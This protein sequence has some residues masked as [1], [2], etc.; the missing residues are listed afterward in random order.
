MLEGAVTTPTSPVQFAGR[1]KELKFM[2]NLGWQVEV[3]CATPAEWSQMLDLF[4]DANIY[5]TYAYGGVRWG[6]KNLSRIVLKRDGEV[7]GM[8][9]LRIVRPTPLKFGMAYLRWG[10]LCERRG[11]PLHPEVPTTMA[12]ALEEEYAGK[13][14]LFVRVLSNAFAGSPRAEAIRTA[15]SSFTR[16]PLTA[17]N[18]YRTFVLDLAP[19]L[20]ELRKSLDPKWRNKLSG[21]EKN[22]LK[23]VGGNGREEYKTFCR[24]YYQMRRRKAFETAVDVEEFGQIQEDLTEPHRMRILICKDKGRPVAGLVASAMGDSAIYLLGATSDEGLN[25]KGAYILQ[26]TLIKWLKENGI[27]WYDLGGIDPEGNPGVYHF[28][29]GFSGVDVCQINPLV[30]CD[31]AVS[32]AIV[33]A[34]LAMQRILR[35]SLSPL[36]LARSLKQLATRN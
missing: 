5:Q 2:R 27:R 1:E 7:L 8:A 13:R 20:E 26:W 3:D 30:A 11:R 15:F 22:N 31:S 4:D 28:K 17:G 21:A 12:R 23:V 29:R 33:K 36:N 25:S 9:Q 18:T 6:E 35:G 34:G 16:E 24:L 14:R 32:S 10:P 19:T